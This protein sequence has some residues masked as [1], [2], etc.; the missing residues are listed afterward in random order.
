MLNDCTPTVV[1]KNSAQDAVVL[2]KI[3]WMNWMTK[4][5]VYINICTYIQIRVNTKQ[6]KGHQKTICADMDA[7]GVCCFEANDSR[8]RNAPDI[9]CLHNGDCSAHNQRIG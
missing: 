8:V 7:D 2:I 4:R 6:V 1:W 3:N 5:S 9:C